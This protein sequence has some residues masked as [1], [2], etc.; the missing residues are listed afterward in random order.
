MA[1]K[2]RKARKKADAPRKG[3]IAATVQGLLSRENVPSDEAIINEVKAKHRGTKFKATHL[4]WY[5]TKFK[6]GQLTGQENRRHVINQ[7]Q[8]PKGRKAKTKPAPK[9]KAEEAAS[10]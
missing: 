6:A 1:G 10:A 5:K 4:A 7:K 2:A 3:S 9:K 8:R